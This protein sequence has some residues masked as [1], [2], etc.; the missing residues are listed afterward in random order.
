M[1]QPG[2]PPISANIILPY[3]SASHI[4]LDPLPKTL[5]N[6][7][8]MGGEM[9]SQNEDRSGLTQN[10]LVQIFDYGSARPECGTLFRKN[11][12]GPEQ[13]MVERFLR[14]TTLAQLG[15][16][17]NDCRATVF[18]EPLVGQCYP[19]IVIVVWRGASVPNWPDERR[20]LNRSDYRL[21]NTFSSIGD[22]TESEFLARFKHRKL[23]RASLNR[24]KSSEMMCQ[25]GKQWS[26]RN[27]EDCFSAQAIISIEAKIGNWNKVLRQAFL[28]RWFASHSYA[29]VPRFPTKE[30]TDRARQFGV[31]VLS[32]DMRS[33]D[34]VPPNQGTCPISHASWMVHDWAWKYS[35]AA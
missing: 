9:S 33:Y 2:G 7:G 13:N 19:D 27:L 21:M 4:L 8:N 26:P 10:E 16:F 28:N 1:S 20:S 6:V 14:S 30:K 18:L 35:T 32:M 3:V 23:S 22:S 15:D 17:P 34:V 5:S 29:L 31:G 12:P 11:T 24:L 25:S